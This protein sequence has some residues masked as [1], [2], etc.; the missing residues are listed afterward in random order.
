M[1]QLL[2]Q[3]SPHLALA[4]LL[5]WLVKS[6]LSSNE[7][8]KLRSALSEA[9]AESLDR[10]A[11]ILTLGSRLQNRDDEAGETVERSRM[12]AA[13]AERDR[14]IAALRDRVRQG[15]EEPAM[16]DEVA[17]AH[18]EEIVARD[19]EISRLR[20]ELE[21]QRLEITRLS[22]FVQTLEPLSAQLSEAERALTA[23][24]EGKNAEIARLTSHVQHLE[25]A[26]SSATAGNLEREMNAS[27]LRTGDLRAEVAALQGAVDSREAEVR[28]LTRLTQ[29]LEAMLRSTPERTADATLPSIPTRALN[30]EL[31]SLLNGQSVQFVEGTAEID[32]GS[33]R[34]LDSVAA[35]LRR[36][37]EVPI[38]ISGHTEEGE[39]WSNYELSRRRAAAVKG[40]LVAKGASASNLT[41]TGR[42]Q[43]NPIADNSTAEGRRVNRRIEF[44]VATEV[45]AAREVARGATAA[46]R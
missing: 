6:L 20:K 40:Y 25:A 43:T 11:E 32:S 4:F 1:T 44:R 45:L 12:R 5:G 33:L 46:A 38:E 21:G 16:A 30:E 10:Q 26:L 19:R 24:V 27:E 22:T 3:I 15:A 7:L 37:P 31:R 2:W 35:L 14:E 36:C 41:D 29:D 8:R 28:R 13:L 9:Q 34:A 42:G 18:S 23:A 39:F 17:S